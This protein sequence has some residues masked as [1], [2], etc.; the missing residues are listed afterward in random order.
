MRFEGLD[1]NLLVVLDAL[2]EEKSVTRAS[3]RL[4][5]S[6]PA[7]S[8]ALVKL[9]WHTGDQLLQKVGR[10]LQLT[11]RALEMVGPV[12]DILI[13]IKATV[14]GVSDF[15]PSV[16]GRQFRIAMSSYCTQVMS[17]P[18]NA[19]L[20]QHYPNITYVVDNL[21]SESLRRVKNNE[22]DICIASGQLNLLNPRESLD[23]LSHAELFVDDWVLISDRNNLSIDQDIDLCS[24]L[25]M[26]YIDTRVDRDATTLVE[27]ALQEIDAT[28]NSALVVPEFHLAISNVIGSE[29]VSIVP[30]LLLEKYWKRYLRVQAPPF[31][32]PSL[33]E[34]LVWHSRN[35]MEAGHKWFRDLVLE[36][37]RNI[38]KTKD[39]SALSRN[40]IPA[41]RRNGQ[42]IVSALQ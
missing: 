19:Y 31:K 8:A 26:R 35:D 13:R 7:L 36:V 15:D 1:L 23:D 9:R 38:R 18:L 11:P 42:Q 14:S 16:S 25:A 6:Q 24:F 5:V 41:S 40:H 27:H 2:L 28:P 32:V 12:K 37:G 4:N 30:S 39:I 29:C 20:E 34:T 10:R 33:H 21:S 3:V 17:P 22:I